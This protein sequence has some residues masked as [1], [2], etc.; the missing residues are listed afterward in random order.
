MAISPP[1]RPAIG[2]ATTWQVTTMLHFLLATWGS[3]NIH[4]GMFAWMHEVNVIPDAS[5]HSW[6]CSFRERKP[7]HKLRGHPNA[8]ELDVVYLDKTN[9]MKPTGPVSHIL[10]HS[11][12]RMFLFIQL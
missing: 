5:Y 3:L 9:V 8:T 12:V 11:S 10:C 4:F 1:G 6:P 2:I 7:A